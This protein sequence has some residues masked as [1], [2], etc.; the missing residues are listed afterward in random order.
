MRVIGCNLNTGQLIL[1]SIFI[2]SLNNV[3]IDNNNN[4]WISTIENGLIQ[5]SND[6]WIFYNEENSGL[7]DNK[8]NCLKYDD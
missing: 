4:L 6:N 8:I 1:T 7:P 5:Y 3:I 2:N